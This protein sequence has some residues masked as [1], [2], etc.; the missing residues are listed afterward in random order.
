MFL[1]R[2]TFTCCNNG[3]EHLY[4]DMQLKHNLMR[5]QTWSA[6]EAMPIHMAHKKGQESVSSALVFKHSVA[7]LILH[8]HHVNFPMYCLILD[9]E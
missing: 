1:N 4:S 6:F 7:P 2:I 8:D 9:K 5:C 3:D